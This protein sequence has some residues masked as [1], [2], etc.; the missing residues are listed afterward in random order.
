VNGLYVDSGSRSS[1]GCGPCTSKQRIM[2][3][4]VHA[5]HR[6]LNN[7]MRSVVSQC[8]CAAG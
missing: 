3:A 7:L 6:Q 4:G 5:E 2:S 8:C 1:P